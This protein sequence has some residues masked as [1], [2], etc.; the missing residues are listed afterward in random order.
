MNA[1]RMDA[2]HY[3]IVINID[4]QLKNVLLRVLSPFN[5]VNVFMYHIHLLD[6]YRNTNVLL[7]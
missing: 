5:N 2:F 4:T 6:R 3:T 1:T 7:L